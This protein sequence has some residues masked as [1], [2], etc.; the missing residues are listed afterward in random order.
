MP[1]DTSGENEMRSLTD[2][3]LISRV[4]A[5]C[6]AAFGIIYRRHYH[7]VRAYL[8]KLAKNME[9]AE[10]M[11]QETF[12]RALERI[13]QFDV[14]DQNAKFRGWLKSI[15][16]SVCV[17]NLSRL[18]LEHQSIVAAFERGNIRFDRPREPSVAASKSEMNKALL[19]AINALPDLMAKCVLS[20]YVFGLSYA[21]MCATYTLSKGSVV[22]LLYQARRILAKR[23][24]GYL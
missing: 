10:D 3:D 16:Y 1:L 17:N 12:I 13:T 4:Q 8:R 24:E 21:D 9:F 11:A 15:A 18:P 7:W 5:G 2:L 6:A 14:D 19:K 23:L 22:Y 20:H